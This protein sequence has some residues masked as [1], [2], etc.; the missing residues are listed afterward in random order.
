MEDLYSESWKIPMK[1]I[2]EDTHKQSSIFCSWDGRIIIVKMSILLKAV[3]KFNPIP[4][5]ITMVLFT[6]VEKTLRKFTC[7]T[8]TQNSQ[9][10]SEKR[11]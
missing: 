2:K 9:L 8:K 1:G 7:T 3:Y 11:E 5:K 10:N 6:D 4:V